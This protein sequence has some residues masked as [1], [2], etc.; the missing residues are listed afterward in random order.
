LPDRQRQN[1]TEGDLEILLLL[2]EG[3]NFT[4]IAA[5]LG[6]GYKIVANSATSIK[7]K[8]GVTA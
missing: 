2:G 5:A 3:R 6:L 7:S 1:L 4:E 8:L